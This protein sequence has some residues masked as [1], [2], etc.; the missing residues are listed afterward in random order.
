MSWLNLVPIM[1]REVRKEENKYHILIY[2]YI[3]IYIYMK[4][5]KMVMM[6]LFSGQ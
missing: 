3:Y 5:K 4:S 1:Q 6:N 2:I